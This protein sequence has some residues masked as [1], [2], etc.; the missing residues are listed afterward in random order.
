M[1]PVPAA[2]PA[3][4]TTPIPAP[5]CLIA[6]LS[7][8]VSRTTWASER[9]AWLAPYITWTLPGDHTRQ[10]AAGLCSRD[11]AGRHTRSDST[12]RS[13]NANAGASSRDCAGSHFTRP[14]SRYHTWTGASARSGAGSNPRCA[15][16][17]TGNAPWL[18]SRSCFWPNRCSRHRSSVQRSR[19]RASVKAGSCRYG[20]R[21]CGHS[22][23][24][25]TGRHCSWDGWRSARRGKP[26]CNWR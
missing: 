2:A 21:R 9:T 22:R 20:W 17:H 14:H 26:W 15:W 7:R 4:R 1:A 25:R 10:V 16:G 24:R 11:R 13:R 5:L 19:H 18:K 8:T 3:V 23:H 6:S 12:R